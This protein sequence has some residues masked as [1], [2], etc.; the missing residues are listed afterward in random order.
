MP[1]HPPSLHRLP[2]GRVSLLH[3]YRGDALTP[4]HPSRTVVASRGAYHS[5]TL[6]F[7]PLVEGC[8]PPRA[9]RFVG[10]LRHAD[11]QSGNDRASQVSGEPWCT[12][13]PL[14]DPGGSGAPGHYGAPVPPTLASTAPAHHDYAP[15]GAQSRG[16]RARCLRLTPR[17]PWHAQDSLPAAGQALPG[18]IGYPPGS[19]ERFQATAM[20]S[21]SPI[22]SLA[23]GGVARPPRGPALRPSCRTDAGAP[24]FPH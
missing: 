11:F 10:P 14:D 23:P 22:P 6:L 4:D 24:R 19:N 20:P 18:G 2:E 17:S 15:F 1:R 21:L 7:A 13:A 9:R 8:P 12:R 16:S 5:N 3:R